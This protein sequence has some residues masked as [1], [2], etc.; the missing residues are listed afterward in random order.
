MSVETQINRIV[1]E[2]TTQTNLMEQILIALDG[3]TTQS[4]DSGEWNMYGKN[5]ELIYSYETQEYTLDDTN[6]SSLTPSTSQQYMTINGDS[7]INMLSNYTDYFDVKNN[8]YIIETKGYVIPS[9]TNE[10]NMTEYHI[11]KNFMH[12]IFYVNSQLNYRSGSISDTNMLLNPTDE[13]TNWRYTEITIGRCIRK[14]NTLI[15]I[16]NGATYGIGL[17]PS[18]VGTNRGDGKYTIIN[19]IKVTLCGSNSFHTVN[20]FANIIPSSTKFKLKTNVYKVDKFNIVS[21]YEMDA[22]KFFTNNEF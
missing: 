11:T 19:N 17:S 5:A 18:V 20:S 15:N 8:D 7:S 4:G 3:K 14:T 1:S 22:Y 12:T 16:G 10:E 21:N 6:Y 13:C 2:V 9:Y